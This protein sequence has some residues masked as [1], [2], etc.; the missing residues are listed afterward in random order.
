VIKQVS[1]GE[2]HTAFVSLDGGHVYSMGSNSEGKLGVG[3]KTLKSSNVPCLV[4]GIENIVKVTCGMSHTLAIND[5]GEAY[6]WG[7]GFYGA[8]GV[9][10]NG[11]DTHFKP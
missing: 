6:A 4:E 5:K 10:K 1:C 2:E 11:I 3:D 9:S 8:T 7:Q